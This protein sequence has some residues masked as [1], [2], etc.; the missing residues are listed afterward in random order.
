MTKYCCTS[1]E[2]RVMK[3][4]CI[5]SSTCW[6]RLLL[7]SI[8]WNFAVGLCFGR[9]DRDAR[10]CVCLVEGESQ[11]HH[12]TIVNCRGSS[13]KGF[14]LM[15]RFHT[16]VT[17]NSSVAT[18]TDTQEVIHQILTGTV[19]TRH[20]V[21]VVNVWNANFQS[22]ENEVW[23]M[24]PFVYTWAFAH[25]RV[26][27][28]LVDT[29]VPV[30]VSRKFTNTAF[31]VS[32]PRWYL[33][34]WHCTPV[35]PTSHTHSQSSTRST[36]VPPLKHD[37]PAHSSTSEKSSASIS[38]EGASRRRTQ[39]GV[40]PER[41]LGYCAEKT[42]LL[43]S[44]GGRWIDKDGTTPDGALAVRV[45]HICVPVALCWSRGTLSNPC[46]PHLVSSHAT[47]TCLT[48]IPFVP[49]VTVTLV[50]TQLVHA[51]SVAARH[52]GTV[53]NIC[54]MDK[55]LS[56]TKDN[57]LESRWKIKEQGVKDIGK[58]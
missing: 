47:P 55:R 44:W 24:F 32:D 40:P 28:P 25:T 11:P 56:V 33:P 35:Y 14:R 29:P 54:K 57:S 19:L 53:I 23:E 39:I 51:R 2:L 48:V 10:C 30:T 31:S 38:G 15:D 5:V 45:P 9:C 46:P 4:S 49:W 8:K 27:D 12:A 1:Q 6:T 22:E 36:H 21:T 37:T 3:I 17:E 26:S 50:W 18:I 43:C 52:I 42:P 58:V 13:R 16:C 34:V 7:D 20:V 41:N